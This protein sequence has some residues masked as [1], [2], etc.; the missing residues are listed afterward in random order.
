[1]KNIP[2]VFILFAFLLNACA[3]SATTINTSI[4]STET[5]TQSPAPSQTLTIL[6]T[7]TETPDPNAPEGW[8]GK[9]AQ[10]NYIKTE[11]GITVTWN[12]ELNTWERHI[13][14][15][16]DGVPLF[17]V[18]DAGHAAGY[19]DQMKLHVNIS[20]KVPGFDKVESLSFHSSVVNSGGDTLINV[21]IVDLQKA[22]KSRMGSAYHDNYQLFTGGLSLSF[23]TAERPQPWVWKLGPNTTVDVD[24]IDAPIGPGFQTWKCPMWKNPTKSYIF[25]TRLFTDDQGNL[26]VWLIPDPT[27]P[28]DQYSREDDMAMYLFGVASIMNDF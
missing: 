9:D 11:N 12:T 1:M 8:T 19:T 24:I 5:S 23:T 4:P 20:D 3:T 21:F 6:P 22:L 13:I 16:D 28:I 27:I 14:V 17:P 26:H 2:F 7:S 10:G 15:N 18:N 25:Q